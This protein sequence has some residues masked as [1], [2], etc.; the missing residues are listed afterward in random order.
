M[1][2]ILEREIRTCDKH[3]EA[4]FHHTKDNHWRCDECEK[5]RSSKRYLKKQDI[6]T[7]I[8]KEYGGKCQVCGYDKCFSALHFHHINPSEKE[9]SIS[10]CNKKNEES[11]RKEANKCILLCANCHIELHY[12]EIQYKKVI[13]KNK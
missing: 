1:S 12:N 9:F 13:D 3:G 10:K 6:I 11:V 4:I 8:K 5:E 7:T 2:V